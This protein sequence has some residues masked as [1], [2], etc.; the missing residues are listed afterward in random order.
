MIPRRPPGG[1]MIVDGLEVTPG[2]IDEN[3]R[4]VFTGGLCLE[5]ACA[6]ARLTGYPII[7]ASR[8]VDDDESEDT[9]AGVVLPDGGVLDIR[10]THDKGAWLSEW[11]CTESQEHP[12]CWCTHQDHSDQISAQ[13]LDAFARALVSGTRRGLVRFIGH[14]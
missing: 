13:E 5:L 11:S 6:L 12:P 1:R 10:G 8:M 2:V 9:H 7:V 4:H 14:G 3:A